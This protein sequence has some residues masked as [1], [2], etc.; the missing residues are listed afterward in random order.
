MISVGQNKKIYSI[1]S[2]YFNNT[3]TLSSSKLV[4]NMATGD[5]YS[6]G[7]FVAFDTNAT[8]HSPYYIHNSNNPTNEFTFIEDASGFVIF[9]FINNA[10]SIQDN[11]IY[12]S[13]SVN[14]NKTIC[15]TDLNGNII[16]NKRQSHHSF[17]DM[18]YHDGTFVLT[19]Q[20]ENSGSEHSILVSIVDTAGKL[21][22]SRN[23]FTPNF[24]NDASQIVNTDSSYLL[25]GTSL[26]D[27][28]N[29]RGIFLNNIDYNLN[30]KWTKIFHRDSIYHQIN[31]SKYDPQNKESIMC[32]YVGKSNQF[33]SVFVL[34][35]D[36][37][38][39]VIFY[40]HYFFPDN[41]NYR[42]TSID[43]DSNSNIY[44]GITK[45]NNNRSTPIIAKLD[46]NGNLIWAKN[47][48]SDST[49]IET[50]NDIL[51]A[52][53]GYLT[54]LG[55]YKA[56]DS[57]SA[58]LH[59][60]TL[61]IN[62]DS[63]NWSCD[64]N[65]TLNKFSKTLT[66]EIKAKDEKYLGT[67]LDYNFISNNEKF[68]TFE[69]NP[70]VDTITS[71]LEI[72]EYNDI[73]FSNPN[74]SV[75]NVFYNEIIYKN[76]HFEITDLQGRKVMQSNSN[77]INCSNLKSGMYIINSYSNSNYLKSDKIIIIN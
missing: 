56:N 36:E 25:V 28:N 4:E 55:D 38:G 51:I 12:T 37:M 71:V 46:P 27:V 48:A 67:F 26:D 65:L 19:G 57:I 77:Q 18:F 70:C 41:S 29:K 60:F 15:K 9:G 54:I 64:T 17:T 61:K 44:I 45:E 47:Y 43:I 6:T 20:D 8:P 10:I 11:Y 1:D 76:I 74:K 69:I 66:V 58:N 53:N 75:I 7:N 31:D 73:N 40:N 39:N 42:A 62:P 3:N 35:I 33:D 49:S 24:F 50:I 63:T 72:N 23:F 13:G 30:T 21:L 34:K 5:I 52:K 32:G 68:N 16:W 14:D 59:F 22:I 2:N